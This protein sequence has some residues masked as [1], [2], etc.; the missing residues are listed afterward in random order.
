MTRG[1]IRF[2]CQ[3]LQHLEELGFLPGKQAVVR[4]HYDGRERACEFIVGRANYSATGQAWADEFAR[5]GKDEIGLKMG[6]TRGCVE[7]R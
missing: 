5:N 6:T 3:L 1:G 4:Q 2:F 7:I